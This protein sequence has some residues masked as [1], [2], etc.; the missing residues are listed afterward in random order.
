[1]EYRI[2]DKDRKILEMLRKNSREPIRDIAA[3]T[4]IRP[5]TVH[6]RITGLLDKGVIE[7]FTVKLKNSAVD[8]GLLVYML[9]A[10]DQHISDKVFLSR[11]I[12]EVSG[13][14][15]EYDLILKM[16]FRDVEEFNSYIIKFRKENRL[17]KTLTMV[18]TIG[19]K[20]EL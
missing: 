12:K 19:I 20:E 18:S 17:R 11:H 10:T 16:K 5:S 2:D 14:T 4:G 15:G 1:M 13:I 3:K 6:K 7:S 8:E 9:V